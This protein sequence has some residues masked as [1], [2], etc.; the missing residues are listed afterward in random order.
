MTAVFQRLA[1]YGHIHHRALNS[2]AALDRAERYIA[3]YPEIPQVLEGD[4]C[5]NFEAGRRDLYFRHPSY[6][7][8]SL[9]T[10][11]IDRQKGAKQ[12]VTLD[13][14]LARHAAGKHY[15]LE[16]K[17][18]RGDAEIALRTLVETMQQ[19]CRDQFWIDGFSLRLA[20]TIKRIDPSVT[21]SLHT[22]LAAARHVLLDAPEWPPLRIVKLAD[23]CGV[24]AIAIRKRFSGA[25]M[26]RACAA[27]QRHGFALVLS[28]LFT[29]RDYELSRQWGAVAGYPKAPFDEIVRANAAYSKVTVPT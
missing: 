27:V 29:P 20:Q 8:D 18:G 28:R 23:V 14:L 22:E 1:P 19:H 13:D 25:H 9:T 7:V 6:V 26:A 10:A 11:E 2:F 15:V 21:T 3:T 24:D 5:W 4:V 16:L 17:V 12:L